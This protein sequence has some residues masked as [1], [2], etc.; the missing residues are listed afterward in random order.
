MQPE[1]QKLLKSFYKILEKERTY[2]HALGVMYFDLETICPDK[3]KEDES[4]VLDYFANRSFKLK[5]SDRAKSLIVELYARRDEL[6]ELDKVLIDKE[7]EEYLKTKN[8]TPQFD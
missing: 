1:T 2:S 3:A 4:D 8:F 6:D 5:N 7:Y